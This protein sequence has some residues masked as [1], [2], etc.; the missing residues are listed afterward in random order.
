MRVLFVTPYAPPHIGGLEAIVDSLALRLTRRGHDV[1]VVTSQAGWKDGYG[2]PGD[3]PTGYRVIYVPAAY[4]FAQSRLGVPYPLFA[5]ALG[6]VLRREIARADVVHV[7][8][9]LFHSTLATLAIARRVP[10]KPPIVLTEHVAHV[11]YENPLLDRAQAAAIATLGRW[12]SRAADAVVVFNRNV[13]ETIERIAPGSRIEWIDNGVDTDFFRP[14]ETAE[15]SRLREQ[16]G[17]DQRPRVL[18]GGRAV[19]K[20]GPDVALEAARVG[21]GAFSLAVVGAI[22]VPESSPNVERVG[23]LSRKR[24]AAA[25]RCADALLMPSRGEGLP[26]TIQEA[27]ASGLP[28]VATDDPGY[29]DKLTGFGDAIRLLPADGRVM[30]EALMVLV[31][32]PNARAAA[33]SAVPEARRRFSVDAFAERHERLYEDLLASR[34]NEPASEVH[35]GAQGVVAP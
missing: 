7:H 29:R 32:D 14:A 27:L 24:M 16:F 23:L 21:G 30:G 1:T 8:G 12:S 20:K 35:Y 25:L 19:A 3:P 2:T 28:V 33:Q 10:R 11:P 13:Q 4:K 26:V 17:W 34:T 18:F 22:S 31:A 15:R 5:P 6:R 9:F